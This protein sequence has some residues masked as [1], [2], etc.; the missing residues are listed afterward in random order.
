MC[1]MFEV[2]LGFI[3]KKNVDNLFDENKDEI[4]KEVYDTKFTINNSKL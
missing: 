2:Y 1:K 3:Q 4:T